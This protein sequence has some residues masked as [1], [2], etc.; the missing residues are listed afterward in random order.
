MHRKIRKLLV[1][2]AHG[3]DETLGAGGTIARLADEGVTVSL[4]I[5]TNDDGSRSPTGA[6]VTNRTDAIELAA[7]TLGIE[8]VRINEFGDNRLDTVSHLEI[9]RVVE[10]EVREF[11][12][13]TIFSTSMS[14]L[15]TD[16][17]LV[18]R[19]ARVAGRP[20]KGSVQEV[21]TFEIRSAT[22]I[23]EASGLPNTFRPN[24]WQ[25]LEETHLERKIEALRAYG[26][27]LE[28]WPHPRSERGVRALAEYRGSQIS[29]GLAEAFEIV[30][31]VQ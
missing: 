11:E 31:L 6:G 23:G 16:H 29:T 27:E 26:K 1:V 3:D 7:K 14:D 17:A 19:A 2:G 22:D 4:C 28:P 10:Q 9:N 21:R 15:S 12:P 8:R 25:R 18:S 5:L 13:D 30:R 24:C 20:G